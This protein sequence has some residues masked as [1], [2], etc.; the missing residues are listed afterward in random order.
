[1]NKTVSK[2][3]ATRASCPARARSLPWIVASAMSS[4]ACT[5]SGL[6]GIGDAGT[7]DAARLPISRP[8]PP[9]PTS[10]PWDAAA[11][12]SGVDAGGVH[13]GCA[14]TNLIYLV[15]DSNEI[16]TLDPV[17]QKVDDRGA[18]A[19]PGEPTPPD[20]A[21][22]SGAANSMAVDRNGTAWVN[23][24]D[25]R[26]F[27]LNTSSMTCTSTSF[28]PGQAGFSLDLGMAFVSDGPGSAGETLYVSDNGGKRWSKGLG[29]VDPAT[30]TLTPIGPY[31]GI[32]IG[33]DAELSGMPSG[34]VYGFFPT[35]PA[36]LAKIDDQT[37][38]TSDI[39]YLDGVNSS[40]ASSSCDPNAWVYMGDDPNACDGLIGESCGWTNDNE[41]QGYHCAT[42][43]WG[44]GCEPGG[45]GCPAAGWGGAS[46]SC[47]PSA[48]VYMG[49][50][51]NACNGLIG[52]SCGWTWDNEG[53]GYH[54]APT[55]WGTGC[56][57][58]G[59][60]CPPV[61]ASA[62]EYAVAYAGGKFWLFTALAETGNPSTTTITQY[63]PVANTS[64]VIMTDLQDSIV[65]AGVS[66]CGQ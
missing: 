40:G 2:S 34:I 37:G 55:S 62:G 24:Q 33:Y 6:T 28:Q 36:S 46:S 1:M 21:T 63:D 3:M 61:R 15:S 59:A 32:E 29:W 10:T 18:F 27:R 42:T 51:P 56:E 58:G 54:C 25:G 35:S 60:S 17:T 44:T 41:G 66:T 31:T 30:M 39:V 47:D 38:A 16:Y 9:A 4:V 64:V 22:G 8:A 23:F 13:P 26:I 45:A 20:P 14:G 53:Q 57:P 65:G 48:W 11:P 50:D 7:A 43:S 52:E 49:N 19:C 5:Q 12:T